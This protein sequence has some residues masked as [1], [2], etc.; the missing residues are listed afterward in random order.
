MW[1]LA[2]APCYCLSPWWRRPLCVSSVIHCSQCCTQIMMLLF[3]NDEDNL[4]ILSEKTQKKLHF[5]VTD[6]NWCIHSTWIKYI[7]QNCLTISN[8][9]C[10]IW[11]HHWKVKK[12]DVITAK[13]ENYFQVL[14]ITQIICK[15]IIKINYFF[16]SPTSLKSFYPPLLSLTHHPLHLCGSGL[17]V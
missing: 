6:Q 8:Q 2:A 11:M 1:C 4:K 7:S 15:I 14:N 16:L 10:K 17:V 5:I 3:Y 9:N 12:C 13:T